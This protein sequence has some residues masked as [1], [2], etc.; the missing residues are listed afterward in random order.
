MIG[1]RA[2]DVQ[3]PRLERERRSAAEIAE[4]LGVSVRTVEGDWTHARTWLKR[5]L[6]GEPPRPPSA[7]KANE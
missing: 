5:E 6:A 1:L 7:G 4:H 2:E 3:Q